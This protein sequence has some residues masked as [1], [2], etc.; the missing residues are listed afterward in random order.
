[1][2]L[3]LLCGNELNRQVQGDGKLRRLNY[4]LTMY[5]ETYGNHLRNGVHMGQV[6]LWC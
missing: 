3:L 2:L 6:F 4:F 1:L 5:L